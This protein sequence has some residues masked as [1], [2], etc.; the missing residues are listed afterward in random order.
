MLMLYTKENSFNGY[1]HLF[2]RRD[3]KALLYNNLSLRIPGPNPDF[4]E[5]ADPGPPIFFQAL[6]VL[7][8]YFGVS[9]TF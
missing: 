8:C 9:R 3:S 7:R 5:A 6:C 4:A 1:L 2:K